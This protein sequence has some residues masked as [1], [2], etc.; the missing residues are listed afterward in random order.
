MGRLA[1]RQSPLELRDLAA[2]I[3][4][5]LSYWVASA[6]PVAEIPWQA[7][8]QTFS[9]A[10]PGVGEPTESLYREDGNVGVATGASLIRAIADPVK[11]GTHWFLVELY[12]IQ[13]PHCWYAVP[14]VSNLVD[15]FSGTRHLRIETLNCH[16]DENGDA[17][18]ILEYLSDAEDY[19]TFLLCPPGPT[20]SP[21]DS[22]WLADLPQRAHDLY[23]AIDSRGQDLIRKFARCRRRFR[24]P[25]GS[26]LLSATMV[27]SWITKET[28]LEPSDPNRFERGA[29]F[30]EPHTKL[31]P[32]SPPGLPGWPDDRPHEPGVAAY[33]AEDRWH[34]ALHGFLHLLYHRY[35]PHRHR[36]ALSCARFLDLAFPGGLSS[37]FIDLTSELERRGPQKNLTSFRSLLRTWAANNA[38]PNPAS[39]SESFKACKTATC[40]L[41]S[42]LHVTVTATASRAIGGLPLIG[43]SDAAM[44]ALRLGLLQPRDVMTFVRNAVETFLSCSSCKRRF[45]VDFEGCEYGRCEVGR[46]W[47]ALG[48]WLWRAHNSVSL[49]VAM[50]ER[51]GVDR[52][53]PMYQDCPACWRRTIAVGGRSLRQDVSGAGSAQTPAFSAR[54]DVSG[55]G[56]A[57]TPAFSAFDLDMV[58]HTNHVFWYLIRT[59]VGIDRITFRIE[60]LPPEERHDLEAAARVALPAQPGEVGNDP[61]AG[62]AY[63]GQGLPPTDSRS[64]HAGEEEGHHPLL[65]L[66]GM[67][68]VIAGIGVIIMSR[69]GCRPMRDLLMEFEDRPASA[70]VIR[71]PSEL[72]PH[73]SDDEDQEDEA[74]AAE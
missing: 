55:A 36:A 24:R 65:A 19:P 34:D 33:T 50:Q 7:S 67:L 53:W 74:A 29:D 73:R 9:V 40:T 44:K 49:Q 20:P 1:C 22:T 30:V 27:A 21:S 42:L 68:L 52:R 5:L 46:D 58:F 47:R 62:R 63:A 70:P 23:D 25:S 60:D 32:D 3:A 41:W 66:T 18:F 45:L 43:D 57:Q 10:V 14:S 11:G 38:M 39:R 28:G 2:R 15:G 12:D 56:S 69:D 48:L 8:P 37:A 59:Y 13:C 35:R 4:L 71:D 72:A 61:G 64:A 17:C 51:P 31:R 16:A 26:E 6:D 54:Q